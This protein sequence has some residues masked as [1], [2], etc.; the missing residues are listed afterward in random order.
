M[1]GFIERIYR[2]TIIVRAGPETTRHGKPYRRSVFGEVTWPGR[3]TLK[4]Y[5]DDLDAAFFRAVMRKLW[6][7][8]FHLVEFERMGPPR[9][10][11]EIDLG[12]KGVLR[13]RV[14]YAQEPVLAA[15]AAGE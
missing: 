15:A 2:P 13:M 10:T 3:V 4:G 6:A 7:G 5:D 14:R 1:D 8:G 12:P 9:R 11:I